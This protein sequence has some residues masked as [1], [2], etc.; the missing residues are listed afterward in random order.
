MNEHSIACLRMKRFRTILARYVLCALLFNLSACSSMQTVNVEEAMNY[1]PPR[2]V[3][4]GSLVE[5]RTLDKKKAKFRVTEI[6]A[7]GLGGKPGFFRF[8]DMDSLKVEQPGQGQVNWGAIIGGVL[9]V[10]ALFFLIDNADSV[11][12][13]S[14]TPCPGAEP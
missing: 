11:R 8:E 1:S 2:D 9:G 4:F 13:C 3:D 7:D 6:T 10:A 5:V 14:G 12:V